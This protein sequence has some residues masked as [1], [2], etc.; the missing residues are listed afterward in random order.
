MKKIILIIL[1]LFLMYKMQAQTTFILIRH[2]EKDTTMQGATMM[3]ANPNLSKSGL[4][5][6]ENLVTVLKDYKPDEI[7]ST[8]FIRTKS[9]VTP[10]AKKFSKEIVMYDYTKLNSFADSLLLKQHKTIVIAGHN[11]TTPAL[12]NLLIKQNKF[13]T[14]EETVYNKIFIVT[15]KNQEADV[16]VIT[17]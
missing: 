2:A 8:N 15:V 3:N 11:N 6:A 12:V 7:Y 1:S 13:T 4:Q 9:T 16:K 10:L 5:R 17:Y 14:L